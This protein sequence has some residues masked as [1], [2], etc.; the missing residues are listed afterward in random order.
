MKCLILRFNRLFCLFGNA[1]M[2]SRGSQIPLFLLPWLRRRRPDESAV[3]SVNIVGVF[4]LAGLQTTSGPTGGFGR[5]FRNPL[6]FRDYRP[7]G[8]WDTAALPASHINIIIS[9]Q[10]TRDKRTAALQG[11]F[12][13][14]GRG[15]N[16][17][18]TK[19]AGGVKSA[20]HRSN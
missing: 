15:N 11:L 1:G 2:P 12:R 3:I 5:L 14:A 4:Q 18:K 17:G 8:F 19:E 10:Q 7:L 6:K 16:G 13:T 9:V 20:C